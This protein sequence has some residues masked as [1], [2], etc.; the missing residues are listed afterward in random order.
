MVLDQAGQHRVPIT[1]GCRCQSLILPSHDGLISDFVAECAAV[2]VLAHEARV[3][4]VGWLAG[5]RRHS[6]V[7][8]D[9]SP[10][11]LGIVPLAHGLDDGR[12]SD[13]GRGG[14]EANAES[15]APA[16]LLPPS[17]VVCCQ[18]MRCWLTLQ[19]RVAMDECLAQ[20]R[21]LVKEPVMRHFSNGMSLRQ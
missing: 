1:Q 17:E 19:T 20:P 5:E 14:V 4:D 3:D 15:E 10:L 16:E 8:A 6:A 13:P 7:R 9:G 2:R 21:D 12:P 18:I 11:H